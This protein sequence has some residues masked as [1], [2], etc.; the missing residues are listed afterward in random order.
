VIKRL[1]W[2]FVPAIALWVAFG[3]LY[4]IG[5]RDCVSVLSGTPVPGVSFEVA[6]T[7]GA[8]YVLAWFGAIL[9]APIF[10]I[11]ALVATGAS[12]LSARAATSVPR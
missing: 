2:M 5:A 1:S 9:V 3:V 8:L 7:L 11:A 6:A 12:S 10:A 4:T